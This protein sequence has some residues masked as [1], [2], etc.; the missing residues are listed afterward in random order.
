MENQDLCFFIQK[1]IT[2][3]AK[4]QETKTTYQ[5][6]TKVAKHVQTFKKMTLESWAAKASK[7]KTCQARPPNDQIP[8]RPIISLHAQRFKSHPADG[9]DGERRKATDSLFERG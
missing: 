7:S 9:Q 2:N 5:N 1:P 4:I 3:N 6:K 8:T